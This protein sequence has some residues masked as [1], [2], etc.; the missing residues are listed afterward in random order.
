ML[1]RKMRTSFRLLRHE[2]DTFLDKLGILDFPRQY[3]E[4]SAFDYL[5]SVGLDLPTAPFAMNG[6]KAIDIAYLHK[7]VRALQ[8][9]NVLEFG[10]GISSIAIAHA[11]RMNRRGDLYILEARPDWAQAV[12][13]RV[14]ARITVD[15]PVATEIHGQLCHV[16]PRLPDIAPDFIYLDGPDPRDVDGSVRGLTPQYACAADI[17][18]YEWSLYPGAVIVVDGRKTNVEF[19]RT[20]LRRRWRFRYH[21]LH[22]R[23]TMTLLR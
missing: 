5:Q 9:K 13:D 16:F 14:F 10:C 8:P 17:L 15:A 19:L 18:Y 23:V 20:N 22:N 21:W 7:M 6:N 2:P 12:Q 3:L 4:Q 1:T 11:L